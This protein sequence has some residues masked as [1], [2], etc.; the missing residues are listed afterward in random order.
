MIAPDMTRSRSSIG[1]SRMMPL[2]TPPAPSGAA[3]GHP[4]RGDTRGR[5]PSRPY[6][7][8][9]RCPH[10]RPARPCPTD[11]PGAGTGR[12][13]CVGW[14]RSC[15]GCCR[16]RRSRSTRRRWWSCRARGTSSRYR[17]ASTRRSG[18]RQRRCPQSARSDSISSSVFSPAPKLTNRP[19]F[20]WIDADRAAEL[21]AAR[22]V[23]A[24]PRSSALQTVLRLATV[25]DLAVADAGSDLEAAE[26]ALVAQRDIPEVVLAPRRRSNEAAELGRH[27]LDE[28]ELA[29][30]LARLVAAV[31]DETAPGKTVCPCSDPVVGQLAIGRERSSMPS[32]VSSTSEYFENEAV[33]VRLIS[34]IWS[35]AEACRPTEPLP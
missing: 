14:R 5:R 31:T 4:R 19:D 10:R 16:R 26:L 9:A 34:V 6:R 8:P 30:A 20:S 11:R 24:E 18:R 1:A 15:A 13:E 28:V 32:P 33:C 23:A 3:L 27:I 21:T 29:L 25:G 22:V 2:A 12:I 7:C 35:V 17:P